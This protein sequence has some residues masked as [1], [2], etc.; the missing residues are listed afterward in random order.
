[1]TSLKLVMMSLM[2]LRYFTILSSFASY[3][4]LTCPTTNCESLWTFSVVA[5]NTLAMRRPMS[6][7][8]YSTSLLVVGYW[9]RMACFSSLP[10]GVLKT[11]PTPSAPLTDDPSMLTFHFSSGSLFSCDGSSSAAVNSAMKSTRA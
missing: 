6:K 2:R 10:S 4:P 3:S 8:S 1:M 11:I 7:A 9:S 5:P